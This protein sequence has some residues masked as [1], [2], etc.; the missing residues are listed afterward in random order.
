MNK[1]VQK[2][3]PLTLETRIDRASYN[4]VSARAVNLGSCLSIQCN[5][6]FQR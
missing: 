6:T 5:Q 1:D 4:P 2:T 3:Q